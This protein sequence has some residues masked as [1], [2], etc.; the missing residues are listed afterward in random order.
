[1]ADIV[2]EGLTKTFRTRGRDTAAMQDVS[3]RVE[4][5]QLLVLLGPSGCGKTTTLRSIAGLETPD[6]GRIAFGDQ[7][8]FDRSAGIDVRSHRRDIGLVFQTF[9][10]WPH[11]TARRNIEFPLRARRV[12][13]ARRAG[14][15]DAV[16]ATVAL[17]EH[18]LDKLPSELS[19][20][21]Q[22]R[23]A[24]ARAL[25]GEPAVVL[26][27]EPLS[28]L[29]ALLR[30]Q[31]RTELHVL[32]R[33]LGFTGVY[34]THDLTE[35]VSLGDRVA[36]MNDGRIEQLGTP[37]EVFERPRTLVVARLLGL[38]RLAVLHRADGRW[39]SSGVEVQ[40]QIPLD[41]G[42][43]GTLQLFARPGAV[44]VVAAGAP[45]EG[46]RVSGG[47]VREV[48]YLG[49]EVELIVALG[50]EVVRMHPRGTALSDWSLGQS[51]DL[52]VPHG[53][54]RFY[55]GDGMLVERGA[56]VTGGLRP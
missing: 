42:S 49:S 10:L 21:Q 32:H 55:D 3:F 19:G 53:A 33:K 51:V 28:N 25:V 29:D 26:F 43:T 46:L 9:A 54:A 52:D 22:Q 14:M 24:L 56:V 5:G 13:R 7:V 6:A 38:R 23:V 34:V 15:V 50:E 20:G 18:L 27:D 48:A 45:V 12:P 30:E 44:R 1:M 11:L 47:V 17:G 39:T 2:V 40:G 35:A 37:Q 4:E 31:L 8:V 16:A 36:A 41:D